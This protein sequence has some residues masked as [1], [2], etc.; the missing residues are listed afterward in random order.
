[1]T[2]RTDQNFVCV[3]S[4]NVATRITEENL[5]K[6]KRHGETGRPKVVRVAGGDQ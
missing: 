5:S 1:M 3:A 2:N 6:S 4:L